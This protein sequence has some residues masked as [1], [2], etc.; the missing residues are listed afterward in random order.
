MLG[1][2]A[3][4]SDGEPLSL[5]GERQRALLGLLLVHANEV[6]ARD[7]IADELWPGADTEAAL[8]S[9]HV[10]VSSLRKAL[11]DGAAAL[12]TRAPGYVLEVLPENV[13]ARRFERLAADGRSALAAEASDRAAVL[14]R[15]ALGLWR[16][17]VLADLSDARFASA[18]AARLAELRIG[19]REDL[20]AADVAAGRHEE[21]CPS[22]RSS[23]PRSRSASARGRS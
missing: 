14:L 4:R 19:A 11:G 10:A 3:V 16:G 1:P 13:D 21:R 7:T 15:E 5:G 12:V 17:D 8:R 6:V 22:S 23:S 20:L 9:L 18:E 2:L